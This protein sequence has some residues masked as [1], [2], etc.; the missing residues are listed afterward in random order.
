MHHPMTS[1]APLAGLALVLALGFARPAAAATITWTNAAGGAWSDAANWS[2]STVPGSGDLAVLPTLASNYTVTLSSDPAASIQVD[3]GAT[4]DLGAQSLGSA[5]AVDNAGAIVNFRG[6]YG[7][8]VRNLSGGAIR[9]AAGE[10][11]VLSGDVTNDGVIEVGPEEGTKLWLTATSAVL[12]SGTVR[13]SGAAKVECPL[14]RP[15]Y[16]IFLTVGAGQ[17]LG[18]AGEVWVPV[19]NRGRL[20]Q[21]TVGGP[22]LVLHSMLYNYGTIRVQDGGW[23]N[24][25]CPLMKQ[26]GGTI[27]GAGGMFT[28][29]VGTNYGTIDNL[30]GGTLVADGGDLHFSCGALVEGTYERRGDAGTIV[31]DQYAWVQNPTVA[32][33]AELRIDGL[34]DASADGTALINQGT[35]RLRGTLNIGGQAGNHLYFNG[36]GRLVLEG[37]TLGTPAG[38]LLTNSEGHTITGCGTVSANLENLGT[39]DVDCGS[40][41]LVLKTQPLDNRGTIRVRRGY[42][43]VRGVLANHAVVD[44]KGGTIKVEY[45]GRIDNREG[46]LV[47]GAGHLFLGW[48]SPA[49]TIVGGTL[50]AVDG[51]AVQNVG[52][53]VLT[54][55]RVAPGTTLRTIAGATTQVNGARFENAGTN[56]ILAGGTMKVDAATA[57]EQSLGTTALAGGT[58]VAPGGIAFEGAVRGFGTIAG[59]VVNSGSVAPD[60]A[61]LVVQGA[62]RQSQAG[63][64][65]VAL[66]GAEAA[67]RVLGPAT[68]DGAVVLRTTAAFVPVPDAR[69]PV[70]TFGSSTGAFAH[71]DAGPQLALSPV[72]EPGG[73]ALTGAAVVGVPETPALPARLALVAQA[74]GLRLELPGA[75]DVDVRAY[76]VSGRQVATLAHGALPAGVHPLSFA[77]GRSLGRGIY[78]A[79][80]TVRGA[81]GVETRT[82]RILRL[83]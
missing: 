37:G 49:S 14:P 18:G 10:M 36:T 4:L 27:E 12:G 35:I 21:D 83:Q 42:L 2:S 47:A 13:L 51:G 31:C 62:Y 40:G 54:D 5:P 70:M 82:A 32:P 68:L 74:N 66:G 39:I 17:T 59:D 28:M 63:S 77:A 22:E 9:V 50:T 75:A 20:V 65:T 79:R 16:S 1:R 58:L 11:I 57:Y 29:F 45:G 7:I 25:D 19:K 56:E 64:L 72:Y 48:K 69:Y 33:D 43:A 8:N 81:S 78:F 60:G 71:L 53:A 38:A 30:N 6:Q 80:A 55:V 52:Q 24:V 34:L 3:G 73:F 46:S 15:Q 61:G 26:Y 44:G 67:L 23:I 41:G 76:D